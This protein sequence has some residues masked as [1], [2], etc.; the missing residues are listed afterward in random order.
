ME[1]L[2]LIIENKYD[3]KVNS[4]EQLNIKTYNKC[5]KIKSLDKEYFFKHLF[6]NETKNFKAKLID[7]LKIMNFFKNKD[8]EIML[9]IENNKNELLTEHNSE[10]YLLYEFQKIDNKNPDNWGEI[11]AKKLAEFHKIGFEFNEEVN[12]G[13]YQLNKSIPDITNLFHPNKDKR[14]SVISR[15]NDS[16]FSKRLE[17]DLPYLKELIIEIS[18]YNHKAELGKKSI[19]HYDLNESNILFSQGEFFSIT[20][21]DFSHVGHIET[22]LIKF[23][24]YAS[25]CKKTNTINLNKFINYINIYRQRA[26]ELN[27]EVIIDNRT[28]FT[29]LLFIPLRRLVYA[30]EQILKG[31]ELEFL[32]D[33]D[34]EFLKNMKSIE[35]EFMQIDFN[36]KN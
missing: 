31:T 14:P 15:L 1:E 28:F 16:E 22:D 12:T 25:Y 29:Y 19:L 8:I 2:R 27:F 23:A 30:A 18:H 9:P 35:N 24:R 20:D 26:K 32:Y 36:K 5:Y 17:K 11:A 4:I 34:I 6:N 33:I 3:I 10:F 13:T 21:F 7:Q